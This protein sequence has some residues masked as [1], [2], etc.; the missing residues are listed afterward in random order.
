M[1]SFFDVQ[2]SA[3]NSSLVK[4]T[5]ESAD[6]D[7]D[8]DD[9]LKFRINLNPEENPDT[10]SLS[11]HRMSIQLVGGKTSNPILSSLGNKLAFRNNSVVS[12]SG[13]TDSEFSGFLAL[14]SE[15][16]CCMQMLQAAPSR[17]RCL[18]LSSSTVWRTSCL[19][20][21][22]SHSGLNSSTEWWTIVRQ[23]LLPTVQTV[24]IPRR[25]HRSNPLTRLTWPLLCET[26]PDSAEH[27]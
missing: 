10:P 12:A 21:E 24:G 9:D 20:T 17:H 18:R 2:G 11:L 14:V 19:A 25:L 8:L 15:Q 1:K 13:G 4:I 16:Q 5:V 23:R 27:C 26:S 7:S 3:T 6:G 22:R